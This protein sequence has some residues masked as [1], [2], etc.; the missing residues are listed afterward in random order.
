MNMLDR[1]IIEYREKGWELLSQV[2]NT[3]QI[4]KPKHFGFG[5]FILFLLFIPLTAGIGSLLLLLDHWI[6]KTPMKLLT[7]D[8]QGYVNIKTL[9][10]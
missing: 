4:R 3:A 1:T 8:E 6:R 10:W 9:S 5:K 7:C 2:G